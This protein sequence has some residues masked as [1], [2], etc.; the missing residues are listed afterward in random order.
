MLIIIYMLKNY[1]AGIII[2]ILKPTYLVVHSLEVVGIVARRDLALQTSAAVALAVDTAVAALPRAL[3][4]VGRLRGRLGWVG[5]HDG[6]AGRLQAG[7]V[8][9]GRVGSSPDLSGI[10]LRYGGKG[11]RRVGLTRGRRGNHRV[12]PPLVMGGVAGRSGGR[13]CRWGDGTGLLRSRTETAVDLVR[14]QRG[15][16]GLAH[17]HRGSHGDHVGRRGRAAVLLLGGLMRDGQI[18]TA[19]GLVWDAPPSQTGWHLLPV[20]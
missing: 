9:Y 1:Y 4:V 20:S 14:V 5:G 18:Q 11:L 15:G 2:I 12:L 3:R 17:H 8:R 10:G 16:G 6:I 19:R 7:V 13:V